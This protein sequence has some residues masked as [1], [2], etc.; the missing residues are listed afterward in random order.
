MVMGS[1][2]TSIN[3]DTPLLISLYL[4]SLF[5]LQLELEKFETF[6][7][8]PLILLRYRYTCLPRKRASE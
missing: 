4:I 3:Q 7:H 2:I 6:P 5:D 8:K 1:K